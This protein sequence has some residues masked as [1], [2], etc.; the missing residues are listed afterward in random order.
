MDENYNNDELEQ[1]I[2]KDKEY[3]RKRRIKCL[4][5][6]IPIIVVIAVAITLIVVFRPKPDNKIICYY[7]T[8]KELKMFF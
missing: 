5:I 8:L 3:F 1:L 4:L 2:I 6:W 7:K